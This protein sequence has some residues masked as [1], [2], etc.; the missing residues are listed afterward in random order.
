MQT[1]A[2]HL[3]WCKKR[4]IEYCDMGDAGQAMASFISDLGK[5]EETQGHPA[6]QLAVGLSFIGQL[7]TPKQMKD[8]IEGTN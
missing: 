1:R 3:E 7:S 6:I 8:F 2:E 4:A 5:H